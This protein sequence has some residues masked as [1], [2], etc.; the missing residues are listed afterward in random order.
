ME[1][2]CY[3]YNDHANYSQPSRVSP[4]VCYHPERNKKLARNL[5]YA[6]FS[7]N[8]FLKADFKELIWECQEDNERGWY[9]S[10][11]WEEGEGFT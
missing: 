5:D 7:F 11:Y 8:H 9:Y 4:H 10:G 1:A 3:G 2:A 6:S